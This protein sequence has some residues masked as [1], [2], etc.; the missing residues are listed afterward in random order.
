MKTP[1]YSPRC[2][3]VL[4]LIGSLCSYGR[5]FTDIQGRKLEG[6]LVSVKGPQAVIKR[7]S[8]SKLFTM[9]VSQFSPEDKKVMAD[10]AIANTK[11]SFD[12]KLVKEKLGTSKV[13]EFDVKSTA[14]QWAYKVDVS[15]RS[16]S[17]A[18]DL[19]V[20]YWLFR[21]ADDGKVK[22]GPR[23][24]QA[25]SMKLGDLRLG[26]SH[27]FQTKPV[28]LTKHEL[29]GGFYYPDGTKN[30][31]RD[32]I[33]GVAMRFFVGQREVFSWSTDASLLKMASWKAE[34]PEDAQ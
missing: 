27:Q 21:K 34:S 25:G 24:Q 15:N 2:V 12:V 26:A 10:F 3:L 33:G 20:D 16:S 22:A 9:P 11:Y 14:E 18:A 1:C 28:V 13:K 29:D 6:E 31:S 4:C 19:R 17:D 23:V 5:E 8:D 30:K 32:T 7:T